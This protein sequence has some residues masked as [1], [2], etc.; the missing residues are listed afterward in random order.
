MEPIKLDPRYTTSLIPGKCIKCLA[1]KELDNCLFKLL[2][3]DKGDDDELKQRFET[4]VAFLRSPRAKKLLDE[5][6]RYLSDG[7][8]VTVRIQLDEG[9]PEYELKVE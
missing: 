7:K 9:K 6:E 4:L 2:G 8:K 3:D 5:S 1:E